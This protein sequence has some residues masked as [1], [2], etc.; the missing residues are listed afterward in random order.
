MKVSNLKTKINCAVEFGGWN[1]RAIALWH[2]TSMMWQLIKH[3]TDY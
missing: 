2:V 1:S 3:E